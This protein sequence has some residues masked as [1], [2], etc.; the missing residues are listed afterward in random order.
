MKKQ[1]SNVFLR[2]HQQNEKIRKIL[3]I[4]KYYADQRFLLLNLIMIE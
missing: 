4:N 3:L 2:N 1:E